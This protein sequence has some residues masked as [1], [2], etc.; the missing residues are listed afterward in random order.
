MKSAKEFLTSG[1]NS[2]SGIFFTFLYYEL[3]RK[4]KPGDFGKHKKIAIYQEKSRMQKI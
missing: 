3:D 1:N 4:F 2:K